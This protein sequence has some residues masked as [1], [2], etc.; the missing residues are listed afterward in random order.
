MPSIYTLCKYLSLINV[1]WAFRFVVVFK[2]LADGTHDVIITSD[3][4][5]CQSPENIQTL[6]INIIS[7]VAMITA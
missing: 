7:D 2:Y 3:K 6:L 1:L 4:S 5:K